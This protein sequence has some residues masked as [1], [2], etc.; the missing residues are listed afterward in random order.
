MTELTKLRLFAIGVVIV[1]IGAMCILD[2]Y[3]SNTPY[4]DYYHFYYL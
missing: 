4:K 3:G 1:L 2:K